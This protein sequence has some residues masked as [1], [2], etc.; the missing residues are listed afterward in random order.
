MIGTILKVLPVNKIVGGLFGLANKKQDYEQ[1]T[2]TELVTAS[3]KDEF[4]A[5]IFGILFI[6]PVVP[7]GE[8]MV[9][10]IFTAF[11]AWPEDFRLLFISIV[12][13]SFGGGMVGKGVKGHHNMKVRKGLR[14]V[15][16]KVEDII[17]DAGS[18]KP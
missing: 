8:A 15:A 7:G 11:D 17:E 18:P 4:W 9:E 12:V 16:D 1:E 14:K 13:A 10:R 5:V 3:W 2:K 6:A